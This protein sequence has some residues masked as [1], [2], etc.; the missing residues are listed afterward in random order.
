VHAKIYE[1][2]GK[3]PHHLTFLLKTLVF[4]GVSEREVFGEQ[5]TQHLT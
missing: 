5:V 2:N 3:R 4:I 1:E